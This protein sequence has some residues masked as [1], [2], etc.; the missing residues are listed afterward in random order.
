[1]FTPKRVTPWRTFS[2]AKGNVI[3]IG[4]LLG[5]VALAWYAGGKGFEAR[6]G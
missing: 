3:Q 6:A 1:M 2:V 5:P 4:G